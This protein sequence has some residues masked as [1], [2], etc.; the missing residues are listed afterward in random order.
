[1]SKLS[2]VQLVPEMDEGG[3][4]GETLDVACDLVANGYRSIVISD[5]G[6]LVPTLLK[7]GVEHFNWPGIG[8]KNP[9]CLPNILKLRKLMLKESIDLLHLRSRLPAWVGW[10][11][12]NSLPG[13]KRPALLTSFHGFYSINKYS[14]IMTKG[15]RVVAVSKVIKNHIIENYPSASDKI[16]V[17]YGGVDE[18]IFCPNSISESRK[19]K[20][21]D[22]WGLEG[23]TGPIILLPGRLTEWK[24]QLTFIEAL[25]LLKETP[26]KALCVGSIPENS[27]SQLLFEKV[28]KFGLEK[29]IHFTGHCDDMPAALLVSDIVVSASSTQPEAFGKVAI[30]AM[31]MEKP[32]VATKHGGSLETVVDGQT[33]WLVPPSNPI[34][35]AG[36]IRQAIE[37]P[38]EC[39][40]RGE[41]GRK[42]VVDS[43]S[44]KSMCNQTLDLYQRLITKK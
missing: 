19:Q 43:F 34:A 1:M 17:I 23:C 24:G 28:R 10:L 40:L 30:E 18:N 29:K 20:L 6:R 37:S 2:I 4:E 25:S 3:V 22:K 9:R 5:G 39:R 42:R 26:F 31:A 16:E 33:G 13:V 8:S 15:Q 36:A 11:A 7:N 14:E 38:A 41:S 21:I 32:V 35:M 12:W 44:I 27:Y